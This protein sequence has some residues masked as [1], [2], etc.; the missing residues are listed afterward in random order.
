MK[1]CLHFSSKKYDVIHFCEYIIVGHRTWHG[2]IGYSFVMLPSL[3]L[4]LIHRYTFFWV[5][6]LL[7]KL[8]FSFY[9]EVI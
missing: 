8:A 1:R 7:S 9:V 5:M 6:L 4:F 3:I 2:N